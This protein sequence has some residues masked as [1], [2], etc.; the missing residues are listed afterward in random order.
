MAGDE[1]VSKELLALTR[2]AIERKELDE[3]LASLKPLLAELDK[4]RALPLKDCEPPLV[5]RPIET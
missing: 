1:S 4:L 3:H 5:F 2:T